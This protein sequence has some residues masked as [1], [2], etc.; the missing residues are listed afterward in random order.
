LRFSGSAPH[1]LADPFLI[2]IDKTLYIFLESQSP[3]NQGKIVAF[4]TNDLTNYH[5]IGT[6]LEENHHLSYPF[7]FD[8]HGSQ[9]LIPESE[10]SG[11]VTLYQF[12]NF[13]LNP[14]K[15]KVLLQGSY[16]DSSVFYHNELWYLFTTSQ[17][18]LE[19]FWS[20]NLVLS[21]FT[22]HTQNPITNNPQFSRSAGSIFI[23]GD[24][25][26]RPSQDC[27]NSYG[28]NINLM[29]II[30]LSPT[31]YS[32]IQIHNNLF[33][34]KFSKWN[35]DGGHH[36]SIVKFMDRYIIASDK[37]DCDLFINKMLYPLRRLSEI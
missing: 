13:P 8:H 35:K 28:E 19:I 29:E 31:H 5:A 36:V 32:E 25:I 34:A 11:E 20:E 6:I 7:V 3:K 10:S 26:V 15:I 23:N 14:K 22:P 12:E 2:V 4:M 33:D 24:K 37:K 16:C 18:G 9:Y 1:T 30:N 27:S 17:Q 21:D